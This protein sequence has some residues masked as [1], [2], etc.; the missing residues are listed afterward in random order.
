MHLEGTLLAGNHFPIAGMFLLVII[1]LLGNTC[2]RKVSPNASLSA[3]ELMVIWG[4]MIVTAGIPYSGLMRYLV[5]LLVAPIFFASPENEWQEIFHPY[6]S[7]W[8]VVT[9]PRAVRG[10]YEGLPGEP[11]PWAAWAKPLFAWGLF[12]LLVYFIMLCMC[13]LL[14]RQWVERERYTFPLVQLPAEIAQ[15]P[16]DGRSLINEF[17][18]NSLISDLPPDKVRFNWALLTN[19]SKYARSTQ[20]R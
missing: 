10:F 17:F 6:L 2:L 20:P 13:V 8:I 18:K 1:V 11:I 16:Q 9:E 15:P 4:M 14:R 3:G 5:P 12:T 19:S 7:D